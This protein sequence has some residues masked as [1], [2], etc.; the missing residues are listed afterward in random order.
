MKTFSGDQEQMLLW[1][2]VW[3]SD[4]LSQTWTTLES[5]SADETRVNPSMAKV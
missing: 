1:F 2:R 3:I 4:E 5:D